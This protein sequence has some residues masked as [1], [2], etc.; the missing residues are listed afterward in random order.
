MVERRTR[1]EIEAFG[2]VGALSLLTS[3]FAAWFWAP[4]SSSCSVKLTRRITQGLHQVMQ[5]SGAIA[6][7]VLNMIFPNELAN[8]LNVELLKL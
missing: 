5:D 2:G 7:E 4:A 3:D 8:S 6:I 1:D